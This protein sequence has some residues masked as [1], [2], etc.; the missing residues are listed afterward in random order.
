MFSELRRRKGRTILTALGLALGIGVVVT[1]GALSTG[2]DHAQAKVLAP[3]TGVGTD[4]SVTRPIT[5]GSN[6]PA[7]LSAKERDQLEKENGG[8]RFGLRNLGEPGS[9]FSQDNFVA[10]SQLSFPQS[11]VA[12]IRAIEGVRSA[13]GAL[14]LTSLHIEGTVP[15]QSAAPR[16]GAIGPGQ[17]G[18][19]DNIDATAL[20]VTGIDRARSA[21]APVTP[22]QIVAG[23]YLEARDEAVLNQAYASRNGI[24]VGEK[25]TFSG[26]SFRVVGLAQMPIGGQASDVYVDL[27][28]LQKLSNRVGRVNTVQVR[29]TSSGKVAGVAA[30][31]ER[32]F[33][34][35]SATTAQDLADRVSGSL[36]DAKNLTN[37]LG[38]ALEIVGLLAAFLI[39]CLLTLSSVTK[40]VRELGTLKALGWPQ[41][42]VVRQVTGE[43]LLQGLL[44]GVLG[45]AIGIG[46]AALITAL[47]PTLKATV[48]QAATGGPPRLIGF[49][50]GSVTSGSTQVALNAPVSLGLLALAVGL[51]VLGGLLS[52]AV[53]GLR[54]A[55]LRPADSLRH[56]D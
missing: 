6:G 37:K 7:G 9:H 11:E 2:L 45:V 22:G 30:E 14:T 3:L 41:R 23:R 36:V 50:Q 1:V 12:K 25:I 18:R 49:G 32:S 21:I 31:I 34:G 55:R 28:T 8:T 5:F 48:A 56:I 29:A 44:G 51:A 47:S 27:L 26:K 10:A 35:S 24:Q 13:A 46:G 4:L 53:G 16:T 38:L 54:A 15:E 52:G 17:G 33:T 39:A 42:L 43:S 19:P 20:T 40:R